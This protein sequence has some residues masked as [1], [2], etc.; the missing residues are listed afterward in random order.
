MKDCL[1]KAAFRAVVALILCSTGMLMG[2]LI[3]HYARI[4]LV[5][6]ANPKLTPIFFAIP[7][8]D[9]AV[10]MIIVRIILTA[11]GLM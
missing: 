8:I 6:E 5:S 4:V 7:L 11:M 1:K 9:S 10:G 2:T 3:G